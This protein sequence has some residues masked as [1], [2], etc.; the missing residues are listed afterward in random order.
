M[1]KSC[2]YRVYKTMDYSPM[3]FSAFLIRKR[4]VTEFNQKSPIFNKTERVCGNFPFGFF[5]S[6]HT[7]QYA[8]L[9]RSLEI[10]AR[11]ATL[12]KIYGVAG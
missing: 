8:V 9:E 1:R 5:L 12:L 11:G 2:N 3:L 6:T 10:A 7:R 4:L